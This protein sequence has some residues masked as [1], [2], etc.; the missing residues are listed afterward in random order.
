MLHLPGSQDFNFG[1]GFVLW[2]PH[3]LLPV[4]WEAFKQE[5]YLM[6]MMLVFL[7]LDYL[8]LSLPSFPTHCHPDSQ[9][10]SLA[11]FL[12]R[13]GHFQVR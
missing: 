7:R 9:K 13:A 4:V 2:Q 3:W 1:H 5:F 11:R 10:W 6:E 8:D 12:R